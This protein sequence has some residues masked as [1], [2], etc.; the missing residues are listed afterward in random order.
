[1]EG[2]ANRTGN[3]QAD[4]YANTGV[5]IGDVTINQAPRSEVRFAHIG[6][7]L[8]TRPRW[9]EYPHRPDFLACEFSDRCERLFSLT[10][11]IH[12]ADLFFDLVLLNTGDSPAVLSK[13]GV[14]IEEVQ[15]LI[16]MYGYP[17][18]SVIRP[19]ADEYEIVMPAVRKQYKVGLMDHM[20]PDRVDLR[21]TCDL[22]DPLYLPP[23]GVY[24]YTLH[25]KSYQRNMPNH[26]Q[27]RL[28]AEVSGQEVCS[29]R[30]HVFTR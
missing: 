28:T 16:Y 8:H 6:I 13:V 1:M 4:A 23:Q 29:P 27:V 2:R 12:D 24:R 26:A 11:L 5:H 17:K 19:A 21:P 18:A 15:Q 14:W 25:L 10:S 22:A 30:L 9:A 7:P 20:T 3:A